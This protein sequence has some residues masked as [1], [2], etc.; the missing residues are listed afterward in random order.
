M[1]AETCVISKQ[2]LFYIA[3]ITRRDAQTKTYAE[4]YNSLSSV[5]VLQHLRNLDYVDFQLAGISCRPQV[6]ES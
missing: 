5:T 6:T 4:L 1:T 2:A 3:V